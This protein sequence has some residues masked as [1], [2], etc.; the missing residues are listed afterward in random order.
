MT[1][2]TSLQRFFRI[3]RLRYQRLMRVPYR[4]QRIAHRREMMGHLVIAAK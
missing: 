4:S 1:L 3:V 2:S